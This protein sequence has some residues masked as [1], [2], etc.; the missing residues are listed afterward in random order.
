MTTAPAPAATTRA[1]RFDKYGGREVLSLREVPM[2]R[3]GDGEVLVE[4]RAAG[5]IPGEAMIRSGALHA[6]F[7]ATFGGP[8]ARHEI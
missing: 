4:V 5:I 1:V 6:M 3:S 7:P 8:P 2:P